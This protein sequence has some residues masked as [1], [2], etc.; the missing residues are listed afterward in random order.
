VV[1][2]WVQ[3]IQIRCS[4][5]DPTEWDVGE[6]NSGRTSGELERQRPFAPC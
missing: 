6:I 4:A 5:A 3:G 2:G 1:C